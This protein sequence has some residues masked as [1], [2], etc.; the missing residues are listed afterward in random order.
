[1]KKKLISIVTVMVVALS[2]C[3]FNAGT[4]YAEPKVIIKTQTCYP[5][6][7]RVAMSLRFF[8][9]KVDLLTDGE[10]KIKIYWPGQLVKTK[11]G[12]SAVQKG[13][14]DGL[15]VASG[16]YFSGIVPEMAGGWMP[17]GWTSTDDMAD[18]YYNYGYL[19]LMREAFD[20]HGLYY[21]TLVSAGSNGFN[22]KFPVRKLEDLKGKK[23]R[24][25]GI[26]G[27]AVAALGAAPVGLAPVEIYSG[28]E[29]GT[30][31]GTIY[32]WYGL[33]DYKYHEVVS[34]ISTPA[35]FNPG[36]IDL[37]F[38]K[39]VWESLDLKYQ[40]AI[41]FAGI[42]AYYYSKQLDDTDDAN[43]VAFCKAHNVEIINLSDEEL[44]RFK[45]AVAPLYELHAQKSPACAK[46]VEILKNYAEMKAA[47]SK[48][49]K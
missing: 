7:G 10:V 27:A 2:F 47:K 13:M 28:L 39:K 23:I 32:P 29:R 41:N 42:Q 20:K 38:N 30:I 18:I 15:F 24:S 21:V 33:E 12:L 19:D 22:T 4:V 43:I 46:Q 8:A 26:S 9:E 34:S 40:K 35:L 14:I 1:M 5:A 36:V 31:D 6:S 17:Y 11:Q 49:K 16:L 3:V 25:G 37:M 44:N 45:A 48:E